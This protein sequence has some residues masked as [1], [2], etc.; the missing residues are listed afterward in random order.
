MKE[1]FAMSRLGQLPADAVAL[2][3]RTAIFSMLLAAPVLAV[4]STSGGQGQIIEAP[5]AEK[6]GMGLVL[7]FSLQRA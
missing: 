4:P 3:V 6:T 2:V 5:A 1:I 7:L